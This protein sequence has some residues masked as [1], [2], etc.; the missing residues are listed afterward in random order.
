[1]AGFFKAWRR[2]RVLAHARLDEAQWRRT[3]AHYPFLAALGAAE[4]QRLR[5]LAI[6]FL[7]E[8][9]MH[10]A[11]G[12]EPTDKVRLAIAAQAC[13]PILE[14]GL[15]WYQGWVGIVV[16]PGGFK[17][18]RRIVGEDGVT[19]EFDDELSG[20][21]WHGGPVVLS[22]ED[23][24]SP[25]AGYNVVIHEFAHKIHMLRG[26]EDGFPAPGAGMERKRWFDTLEA[27]YAR[28]CGAVE[29]GMD[30]LMDPYAAENPAEFFAVASEMFFTDSSGLRE[31]F[32]GL[33][34]ELAAFYR[35]DPGQRL[36]K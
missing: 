4:S 6:L 15:D 26:D 5:E 16:Y 8:K 22:W 19:H 36:E 32:A 23:A 20:E 13:L 29:R 31:E 24:A 7:H 25:E 1:M 14:L 34:R 35:Q 28:F 11:A 17:V 21:A 2:K 27:A 10:G 18:P 12:F 9:Q 33:Y 30:T 3:I